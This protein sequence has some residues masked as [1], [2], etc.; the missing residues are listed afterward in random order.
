L[1]A[2][3]GVLA[4][5]PPG[6][7]PQDLPQSHS[8]IHCDGLQLVHD[9]RPHLHQPMS[10]PQ[11]L[12]Q[13]PIFGIGNPYAWKTIFPQQP[14]EESSIYARWFERLMAELGFELWIGDPAEIKAA[15]VRK[16][17]TDRVSGGL[18]PYSPADSR[19]LQVAVKRLR[20]S[21]TVVQLR[22]DILSRFRIHERNL[23]HAR[24]IIHS[25][26]DHC[27]APFSPSLGSVSTTKC[28]GAEEPALLW[29]Q[30]VANDRIRVA[31][32]SAQEEVK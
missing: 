2:G 15:R 21:R 5:N 12:T 9:S 3:T 11:Q 25:Y 18:H 24:V 22:F 20:F 4:G 27:P 7:V 28:S 26:N 23:L 30:L 10:M 17:K 14:Q 19:L 13:I 8:L 29:N 32:L 16:K 6:L 1:L 31:D